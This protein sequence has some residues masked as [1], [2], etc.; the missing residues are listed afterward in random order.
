MFSRVPIAAALALL[1]AA[2]VAILSAPAASALEVPALAGRV[3]DT[4]RILS[5]QTISLLDH[6]L[7]N[8]E[9]HESTQIVVLTVPRLEGDSL[10]GYALKVAEQWQI[11]QKGLDN[12]AL[13][14]VVVKERKVR[15]EVGYGLEGTLTDLITGRIIREKIVPAFRRGEYD[16]GVMDGVAAMITA[17]RGEFAGKGASTGRSSSQDPGGF[18]V[19][20]IFGL[21]FIGKL[22]RWHKPL[23]AGLGGVF[24]PLLA[25]TVFT[26][27]FSWLVVI[28]LIPL[29]ICGALIATLLAGTGNVHRSGGMFPGMG[30][31]FGG[32]FGGGGFSGGGGGFGGGGA[33]GGW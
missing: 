3:N 28:L 11:G 8:L 16:Q 9:E 1:L 24:A 26:G 30:G 20:L 22:F 21:L 13:L 23:A 2:A 18:L 7:R 6:S 31:G 10:E 33:S 15:I 29:G 4:A 5:P 25:G 12:G 32:G 27:L 19:L 14:L 17:V